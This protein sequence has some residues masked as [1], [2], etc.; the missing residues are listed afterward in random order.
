MHCDPLSGSG[1]DDVYKLEYRQGCMI[2][3]R[4][5]LLLLTGCLL[6]GAALL[7]AR[8]AHAADRTL[9]ELKNKFPQGKF[10]NHAGSSKNNPDGYTTTPCTH[11]GSCS[12]YGTCGCNSFDNAIQCMGFAFKIG[13]DAFGT[14]PRKWPA[15]SNTSNLKSGDYV[16]YRGHSMIII[17]VSDNYVT[18]GECNWGWGNLYQ[19]CNINWGRQVSM[20]DLR[21]NLE[22]V[23]HA[24]RTLVTGT[25]VHSWGDWTYADAS[26]HKRVCQT[27]AS[28]TDTASHQWDKG[29]ETTPATYTSKGVRTYTCTVCGGTKTKKIAKLVDNTVKLETEEARVLKDKSAKEASGSAYRKLALRYA[30]ATKTAVKLK[31]TKVSGTEKYILYG[32]PYNKKYQKLGTYT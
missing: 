31:W 32:A 7:P 24:P 15:D 4:V 18:V 20:S 28:H 30:K 12:Y 8:P 25:H 16:R 9:Q 2:M 14:S 17:G 21:A 27:D 29:K 13:Y 1:N 6:L 5:K 19:T 23:R 10:W 26:S 11:H 3:R 22:E